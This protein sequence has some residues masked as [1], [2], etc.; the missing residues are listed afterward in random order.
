V[1]LTVNNAYKFVLLFEAQIKR[2]RGFIC[3]GVY[4]FLLMEKLKYLASS[5][6]LFL[7]HFCMAISFPA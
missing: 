1:V 4:G 3:E 5:A 2:G 7:M 6:I